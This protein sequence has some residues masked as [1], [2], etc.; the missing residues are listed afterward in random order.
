MPQLCKICTHRRSKAI[1][2][3]LL[4]LESYRDIA[5][6]FGVSKDSLARHY[7]NHLVTD[8]EP[9]LDEDEA[10]SATEMFRKVE[11]A[12]KTPT[13]GEQATEP[14]DLS[15]IAAQ[16]LA[17]YGLLDDETDV[18]EGAMQPR[19]AT[20]AL[21]KA[22]IAKKS[23]TQNQQVVKMR[24]ATQEDPRG[25]A[26]NKKGNEPATAEPFGAAVT[27]RTATGTATKQL[28]KVDIEKNSNRRSTVAVEPRS[29]PQLMTK[30]DTERKTVA[31]L[32]ERVLSFWRQPLM[33]CATREM[34]QQHCPELTAAELDAALTYGLRR[35]ELQ[36]WASIYLVSMERKAKFNA[37]TIAQLPSAKRN[38]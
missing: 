14:L 32:Y 15:E 38:D 2:A 23:L 31:Q 6:R 20:E 10:G 12:K 16:I 7:H 9:E 18:E 8:E 22:N 34:L 29:T 1:N 33:F 36:K 13:Q 26:E 28:T 27:L 4:R 37:E 17:E 21:T 5:G 35:G 25:I 24:T 3:A 11:V 30:D 19:S